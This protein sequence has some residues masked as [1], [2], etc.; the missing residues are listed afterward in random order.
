M[1][2]QKSSPCLIETDSDNQPMLFLGKEKLSVELDLK[3]IRKTQKPKLFRKYAEIF[4]LKQVVN[5]L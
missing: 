5:V 4:M 3:I 2:Y 1:H